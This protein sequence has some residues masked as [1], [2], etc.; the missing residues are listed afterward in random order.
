M[1]GP[2]PC[3]QNP[4]P[5]GDLDQ[6]TRPSCDGAGL[7]AA[8]RAGVS[9]LEAHVDQVN[10]M[11]V[12]PVP[13]GDTGSNMLATARAALAEAELALETDAGLAAAAVSRGALIGAQGNSGVI[14]SQ[15]ARGLAESLAGKGRI[16]GRDLAEALA[17]GAETAY[18]AVAEPVEGTILTVIRDA[19]DAAHTAADG[20]NDVAT[21]LREAVEAAGSSVDRTPELLSVLRDAGV[22]DAGGEGLYLLLAGALDSLGLSAARRGPAAMI[23][24]PHLPIPSAAGKD[25][26]FETMFRLEAAQGTALDIDALRAYLAAI[27]HSVVVA[28]DDQAATVHVHGAVPGE[29]LA[30]AEGLGTLSRVSVEDLDLQ[31][32]EAYEHRQPAASEPHIAVIALVEGDG[33]AALLESLGATVLDTG[34]VERDGGVDR[35]AEAI[36]ATD[37]GD[38]LIVTGG[39]SSLASAERAAQRSDGRVRIV[40]TRN[41]AEA[42]AALLSLDGTKESAA[43][44]AAMT[45]AAGRIQTIAVADS[46]DPT[47][48]ALAA[49]E[50]LPPGFEL[51]TIYHGAAVNR[52]AAEALRRAVATRLPDV[53][54]EIIHGGQADPLYLIAAE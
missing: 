26:G 28:G 31:A 53:E 44:A 1:R 42:A 7:L 47:A 3:Q 8:F 40:A 19:A 22:A 12:F 46:A 24:R 34:A 30:Y 11:N 23:V 49:L 17:R 32:R 41:A 15:I 33:F 51:I 39:S 25:F 50:R 54:V 48:A 10:A 9:N 21:V 16:D 14:A 38:I 27:G 13:D 43:I 18:A 29:V 36:A 5:G 35:L 52:E 20:S 45:A 37:A 2:L 6:M 4:H